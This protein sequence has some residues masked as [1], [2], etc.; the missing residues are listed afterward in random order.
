MVSSGTK[1]G[2]S[3]LVVSRELCRTSPNCR[4]VWKGTRLLD[5]FA[6]A[7]V[8]AGRGDTGGLLTGK[9]AYVLILW[10]PAGDFFWGG[11]RR[12]LDCTRSVGVDEPTLRRFPPSSCAV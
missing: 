11:Y 2:G 1:P 5:L 10:K 8:V 3:R 12:W 9:R 7:A 4:S 6:C